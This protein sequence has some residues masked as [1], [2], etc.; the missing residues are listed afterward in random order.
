MT[1]KKTFCTHVFASHEEWHCGHSYHVVSFLNE[2]RKNAQYCDVVLVVRDEKFPAHK[3][4]LCSAG[5]YFAAV[6]EHNL[7]EKKALEVEL[8]AICPGVMNG[9]LDYVYTGKIN[10]G[11][12]NHSQNVLI[13]ADYLSLAKLQEAAILHMKSFL[14]TENFLGT[15]TFSERYDFVELSKLVYDFIQTQFTEIKKSGKHLEFSLCQLMKIVK[16]DDLVVQTEED[17]FDAIIQ[18][19]NHNPNQNKAISHLFPL[20]RLCEIPES[21]I[22]DKILRE[23]LVLS[24]EKSLNAALGHLKEVM[25]LKGFCDDHVAENRKPRR[26]IE[27]VILLSGSNEPLCFIP[28]DQSWFHMPSMHWEHKNTPITLCNGKLYVTS[29]RSGNGLLAQTEFYNPQTNKWMSTG[30]LPASSYWP[31]LVSLHGFLYLVGGRTPTNRLK[32]VWRYDPRINQWDM[33]AP[34]REERSGPA[35]VSCMNHIY[36][37]G[38]RKS[39]IEDLRSC[40]R[41]SP[42][43]NMWKDI[44]PMKT[45][46]SLAA[47]ANIGH[48]IFVIGGSEDS[49]TYQLAINT[50]E[51]Y[52]CLVD[53]WS[54]IARCHADRVA[55][56]GCSIGNK[57]Y[58]FGGRNQ[59]ESLTSIE[60]YDSSKDEWEIVSSCDDL[61]NTFSI[62]CCVFYLPKKHL[63]TFTRVATD[64]AGP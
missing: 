22:V 30:A 21:T 55:P 32:T 59:Q 29:G 2:L 31:G 52:N 63:N 36:A 9:V 64:N 12:L 14:T 41:Y 44:S 16:S 49:G 25:Y 43:T 8:P 48:R 27:A 61:L 4:V 62:S 5:G 42:L 39:A 51:V 6:F 13:A 34:L 33:V 24:D 53:E 11:D 54:L 56:G 50:N 47:A 38:G 7:R 28:S 17:V 18:W 58:I 60:A 10:L 15:L 23:S 57:I 45:G 1:E 26:V 37:I 20:I 46:R 35:V 19:I 40:E 3:A